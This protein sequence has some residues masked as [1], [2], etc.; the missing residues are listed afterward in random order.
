[1]T[2]PQKTGFTLVEMLVAV[3]LSL[4]M[5]AIGI[6]SY[7]NF[8]E[9]KQIEETYKQMELKLSQVVTMSSKGNLG[10]C[11]QLL[12]YEIWSGYPG[13]IDDENG[14]DNLFIREICGDPANETPRATVTQAPSFYELPD[15]V[16]IDDPAVFDFAIDTLTKRLTQSG[17]NGPWTITLSKGGRQYQF[18][19]DSSGSFSSGSW[20]SE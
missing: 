12:G 15:D 17:A 8:N 14:G 19:I 5:I 18:E 10:G 6:P 13:A 16:E 2:I 4:L 1:M 7:L 11:N 9:R 3:T 20:V